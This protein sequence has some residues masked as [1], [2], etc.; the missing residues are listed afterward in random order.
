MLT[1][2]SEQIQKEKDGLNAKKDVALMLSVTTTFSPMTLMV[3][4]SCTRR[5]IKEEFLGYLDRHL[6][7]LQKQVFLKSERNILSYA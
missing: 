5:V 2:K 3:G 7:G 1:I 4:A 6:E